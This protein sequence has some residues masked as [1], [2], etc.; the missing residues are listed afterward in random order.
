MDEYFDGDALGEPDDLNKTLL[1]MAAY[2]A[3]PT[4]VARLR[5]KAARA[6]FDPNQWFQNVEVIAGREIGRETVQYVSNIYKYYVAY[7]MIQERARERQAARTASRASGGAG[8]MPV[9]TVLPASIPLDSS[10]G[11]GRAILPG[12]SK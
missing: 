11:E 9:P 7:H 12:S 2:N 10:P 3:G 1:A 6:G 4:R 8:G 5:A